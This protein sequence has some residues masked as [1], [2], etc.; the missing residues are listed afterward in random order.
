MK[1]SFKEYLYLAIPFVLS[2][3]TQ[4]LLGA[5]DTAVLGH[6]DDSSLMGGVAIGAVIFNTLYWLFG[7]LRVSTSGFSAQ[8]LGSGGDES[9][10]AYCRPFAIALFV[11]V[12][13]V[14]AQYFIIEGSIYIFQA[15]HEVNSSLKE[16]F[17]I[18]IWGAPFM[19][20]GYVNLGWIMG[21]KL[22]RQTMVLQISMN[23]INI[24]LDLVLVVVFDFGVKGVAYATLFSQIYGFALGM[25]IILKYIDL[26]HIIEKLKEVFDIEKFREI[27]SV[28]SDL[29]IRTI[30]LLIMT[31]MFVAK[32]SHF[33]KDILA[34]NA[35]LFQIQYLIAYFYDGFANASSVF[36][37]KALGQ[38]SLSDYKRVFYLSNIS[39]FLLN[40][41]MTIILLLFLDKLILLFTS[42]P[43]VL[44]QID[45]YSF[46]LFLFPF[47]VGFGL[48]YNGLFSGA[49]FTKPIKNSMS[50]SLIIFLL[51]YFICVPPYQN[52]GLWFAFIAFSLA[53]SITLFLYEKRLRGLYEKEEN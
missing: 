34:A 13:F 37:G 31:N 53:R 44:I 49:T 21:Q 51:A 20:I 18:L 9:L 10:F 25:Y 15:P 14:L 2:T 3:L 46:W 27:M 8:A 35:V 7:F 33:G 41:F 12:V 32:G 24:I 50:F 17:Y 1:I 16:Y 4:P 5:V 26:Q 40:L 47:A 6:L 48:V 19:L 43:E 11:G 22:V 45:L 38:K 28:N 52:S 23:M 39:A 29:F 30:C 42:I 36:A